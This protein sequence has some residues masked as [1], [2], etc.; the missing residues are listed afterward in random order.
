[1]ATK[2]MTVTSTTSNGS[3]I[4][5]LEAMEKRLQV[6]EDTEKIRECMARYG[7]NADLGRS[8]E[9]VNTWTEK[10]VYDLGPTRRFVGPDD[11]LYGVITD[12]KGHKTIENKSQHICTNF[13]IRVDGN[14]AWAEFYSVVMVRFK[15][16]GLKIIGARAE[17]ESEAFLPWS[18]GYNHCEF[19]KRGDQWYLTLRYRRMVG[20]DEWGGKAIKSYLKA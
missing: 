15:V 14:K 4:G 7:F 9:W 20:G 16:E 3:L 17:L 1:M 5:R 10:G 13:F 6:L 2:R 8:M 12:P 11:L 18:C 19:E